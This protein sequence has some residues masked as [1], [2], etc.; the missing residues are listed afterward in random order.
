[1]VQR[2]EQN[3]GQDGINSIAL[4]PG[5]TEEQAE[6][7]FKLGKDAVVFALLTLAK[8]SGQQANYPIIAM[9]H[10]VLHHRNLFLPSR[11][12]RTTKRDRRN[13]AAKKVTK[14]VVAISREK[15]IGPKNIARHIAPTVAAS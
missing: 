10:R 15:W 6:Q 7:I 8:I 5:L 9:I 2:M 4:G 13:P 12:K 3:A 14:V 1:M 11:T